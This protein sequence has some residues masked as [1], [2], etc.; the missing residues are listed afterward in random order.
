MKKQY[1]SHPWH[2]ISPGENAPEE[3]TAFIEIVPADTVKYEIDKKTGYLKIDRPQKFSNIVPALYGFIPQTYCNDKIADLARSIG[4]KDVERGDHDPL[5]VLVLCSHNI[6]HGNLI[7]QAIP[8]G[9]FCMIDKGEADDKIIAVLVDDQIYGKITDIS[10]LPDPVVKRL[11]HYFLTYKSLPYQE[12]KVAI[13][14]IYG[15][16]HA[17]KVIETALEDYNDAN[18]RKEFIG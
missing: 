1:K 17:K 9:G 15:A 3:V 4:A 18:E 5:D 14:Q 16:A 12:N 8:V 6:P 7:L 10:E 2:G 13:D 11:K